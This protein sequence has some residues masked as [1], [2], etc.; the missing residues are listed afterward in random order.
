MDALSACVECNALGGSVLVMTENTIPVDAV[1][2]VAAGLSIVVAAVDDALL[3]AMVV[4][5]EELSLGVVAMVAVVVV[6]ATVVVEDVVVTA[7]V[8]EDTVVA[9][10]LFVAGGV[11]EAAM[12]VV[13]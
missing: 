6:V 13:T 9:A 5:L 12:A 4:E 1:L 7:V 2:A 3:M 8:V 11:V 10:E